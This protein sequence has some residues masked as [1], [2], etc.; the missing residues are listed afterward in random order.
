MRSIF[1]AKKMETTLSKNELQ[2]SS[3]RLRPLF[4]RYVL[5][6]IGAMLFLALQSIADGL[7]VGRLIGATALAAVNIVIPIYTLVTAVAL[8]IGVGTQAQIGIRMGRGDYSGAKT[9]LISGLVG[10][11]FFTGTA[12][13][14]VNLFADEIAVFLG[15]DNELLPLSTKYIHGLMPWLAG[16]GFQLLFD[17]MLKALGHP[18]FAMT[19]MIG[20]ILLNIVSSVIFVSYLGMGTF[21]TGLGT[22][23]SFTLGAVVS[24]YVIVKQLQKNTELYTAH[25]RFSLKTFGH[26]FYNGSSE[27]LTEISTGV[28]VF[29]FNITLMKYVGAAG[30]S[31][32]TLVDYLMFIGTSVILG[33]SNG[34][35]PIISYNWGA[36]CMPRVK[37]IVR[38]ALAS[39]LVCGAVMIF[40]LWVCGRTAVGLF[41]DSAESQVIDLAVRGARFMSLAFLFNGFNILASSFFT[42]IDKPGLSLVVASLRGPVL[43]VSGIL[44]LP[45]CFGVDG[46]WLAMPLADALTAVI[47]LWLALKWKRGL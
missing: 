25:G 5:P 34:T 1:A 16:I 35:I 10:L 38:L 2:L 8:M 24:G 22:G 19:V 33:I 46:I 36:R 6:G 15:A 17:Y 7:I 20:T 37:G 29:L 43:L 32:F 11:L 28:T 23:M 47:V 42:A 39:N 9:A 13:V 44:S 12:T 14:G 27:G 26:L 40:L 21:G 4:L 45:R 41:I 3:G 30:V 31:A 18:R